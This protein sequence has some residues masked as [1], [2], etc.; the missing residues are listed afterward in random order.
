MRVKERSSKK[1]SRLLFQMTFWSSEPGKKSRSS[2]PHYS[3]YQGWRK[4]PIK[5]FGTKKYT[6]IFWTIMSRYF[7]GGPTWNLL[8]WQ[9]L[10]VLTYFWLLDIFQMPWLLYLTGVV[11]FCYNVIMM[12]V[13]WQLNQCEHM[14]NLWPAPAHHSAPVKFT[15]LLSPN[16]PP[17]SVIWVFVSILFVGI[18]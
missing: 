13:P 16:T 3:R 8:M 9:E 5:L 4:W 18:F 12:N 1:S 17:L 14:S 7:N 11:K 10:W 15:S 6:E 2:M